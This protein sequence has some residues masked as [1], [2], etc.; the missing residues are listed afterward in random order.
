MKVPVKPQDSHLQDRD[1]R[2]LFILMV[3][4]EKWR[5]TKDGESSD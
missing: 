5:K 2:G 1:N 4:S 3:Y